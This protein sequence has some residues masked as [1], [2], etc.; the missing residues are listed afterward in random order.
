MFMPECPCCGQT[1]MST[2]EP[3]I[4]CQECVGA[5]DGHEPEEG[6][7]VPNATPRLQYPITLSLIIVNVLIF[8][9]M[10]VSSHYLSHGRYVEWGA[11]WGPFTIGGQWWRICTSNFI[12]RDLSHLFWNLLFLWILGK[13]VE[14]LFGRFTYFLFYVTCGLAGSLLSL[15]VHPENVSYGASGCI[16]GLSGGLIVIYGLGYRT[17]LTKGWWKYFLLVI[18]ILLPDSPS[19]DTAAHLGGLICG[20]ILGF[21]LVPEIFGG[22]KR[23]EQIFYVMGV[24]LLLAAIALRSHYGYLVPVGAA[25][26]AMA[27][28]QSEEAQRQLHF[29]LEENPKS[30]VANTMLSDLYIANLDFRNAEAAIRRALA[31]NPDNDHATYLLGKIELLSGRCP[32][33]R[34][35]ALSK[36]SNDHFKPDPQFP[37]TLSLLAE[38]CDNV[39]AGDWFLQQGNNDA[40]IGAYQEA[41]KTEP[42][43]VTAK[44][45]LMKAYDAKGM[46]KEANAV[47]AQI[48]KVAT[49]K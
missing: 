13:R 29:A 6:Q 42:E 11:D 39:V 16:M 36:V 21:F 34:E 28:N 15:A 27:K 46:H 23:T 37:Q 22:K 9:L 33:A 31:A 26:R 47:M 49:K 8:T 4:L 38:K 14:K 41:L 20:L 17:L 44:I 25:E 43:S 48:V 35:L 12:H 2:A 24:A 1:L 40:A 7:T 30:V 18:Y 5:L 45:G 32:E 10:N 19:S 3:G